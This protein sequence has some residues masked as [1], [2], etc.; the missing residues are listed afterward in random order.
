LLEL[1]VEENEIN[2]FRDL[3]DLPRLNSLILRKNQLDKIRTPFPF[4]PSLYNLNVAENQLKDLDKDIRK[5]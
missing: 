5:I 3:E 2:D 4:L 1:I